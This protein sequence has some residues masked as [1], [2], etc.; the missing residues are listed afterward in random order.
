MK[1]TARGPLD[2]LSLSLVD[3]IVTDAIVTDAIA[4]QEG[5]A[6]RLQC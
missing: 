2:N 1:W 6:G 4:S 5:F 3:T